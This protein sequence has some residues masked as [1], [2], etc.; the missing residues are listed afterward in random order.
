MASVVAT[1][2]RHSKRSDWLEEWLIK[3][4]K[5]LHINIL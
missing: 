4:F 5:Y 2:E 3:S 1:D